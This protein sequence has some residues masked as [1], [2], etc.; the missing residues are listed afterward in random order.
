[1]TSR[2]EMDPRKLE[3]EGDGGE[4]GKRSETTGLRCTN[5]SFYLNNTAASHMPKEYSAGPSIKHLGSSVRE[6]ENWEKKQ[7]T[8]SLRKEDWGGLEVTRTI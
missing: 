2:G 6:N 7:I 3:K 5:G 1:M 4:G 8:G